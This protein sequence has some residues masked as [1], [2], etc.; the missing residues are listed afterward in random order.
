MAWGVTA[1]P[2]RFNEAVEWF[3]TRLPVTDEEFQ[4]LTLSARDSAFTV[5][6]A[7]QL[8]VVQTLHD[9]ID[10]SLE[11]GEGYDVFAKR[12]K[13]RLKGDWTKANSARLLTTYQTNVQTAYNTGRWFQIQD[14]EIIALRP[15]MMYDA[16]ND[17]RTSDICKAIDPPGGPPTIVRHDDPFVLSHWPPLHHKCRSSWRT[18]T[19]TQAEARG[20][21][22][23]GELPDPE[24]DVGFGLAPPER[25]SWS[26]PSE[27]YTES[28]F[29]EYAQKQ[30]ELRVDEE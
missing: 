27:R 20:I 11:S 24:F 15:W 17:S 8:D 14:P 12:V 10:R 3:R 1:D 19:Q 5:A 16:V 22:P 29:N 30:E 18:L 23:A 7:Q 26:P 25:T 13:E 21:S 28:L 6:G 4:R 2:R 9:E